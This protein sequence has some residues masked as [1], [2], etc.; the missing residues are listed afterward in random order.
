MGRH[1]QVVVDLTEKEQT[2]VSSGSPSGWHRRLVAAGVFGVLAPSW[3]FLIRQCHAGTSGAPGG[4]AQVL[5]KLC[6]LLGGPNASALLCLARGST[7]QAL[8]LAP[9]PTEV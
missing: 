9:P 1:C 5:L 3:Q 6:S 2:G 8:A 4:W 7:A